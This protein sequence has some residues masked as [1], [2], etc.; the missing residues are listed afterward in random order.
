MTRASRWLR[1]A[2]LLLWMTGISLL[3]VALE[4]TWHRTSYQE[5]QERAFAQREAAAAGLPGI[6]MP[7]APTDAVA[8]ARDAVDSVPG[9]GDAPEDIEAEE[10]AEF[11]NDV[12]PADDAMR[13]PS[14]DEHVVPGPTE[15][16]RAPSTRPDVFARIEIPRVR[17]SALVREGADD[18]TLEVAVGHL[19]GSSRPG[20]SGNSV[21]A[22]HRDSFFRPLR[23]IAMDD[24][25]R[26]TVPP[27]TY[28]YRV[29]SVRIVE[30]TE[31]SVLQAESS[32]E[33]TLITCYPFRWIGPAPKRLVVKAERVD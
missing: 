12:P 19:P 29:S 31:T 20:E 26:V 11:V 4:A 7:P 5:E 28:E 25:I 22:G 8:D 21:F 33:L 3:G 14:E 18:A 9:E 17:L 15:S 6:A 27:H 1:R 2:E 32:E 13:P 30:P 24:R 16:T 10:I 23:N